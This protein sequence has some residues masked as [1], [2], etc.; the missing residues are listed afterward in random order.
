MPNQQR[1]NE[2]TDLLGSMESGVGCTLKE[3]ACPSTLLKERSLWFTGLP[4]LGMR[5]VLYLQRVGVAGWEERKG[6]GAGSGDLM[7]HTRGWRC[8]YWVVSSHPGIYI[9]KTCRNDQLEPGGQVSWAGWRAD[10]TE[11]VYLGP[12][13][14]PGFLSSTQS[15]YCWPLEQGSYKCQTLILVRNR[16]SGNQ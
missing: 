13:A 15:R 14:L 6:D 16:T 3:S 7:L 2:T 9:R 10:E 5:S 4:D 1:V 8:N 12:P 11:E